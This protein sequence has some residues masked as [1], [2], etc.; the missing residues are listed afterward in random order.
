MTGVD[1]ADRIAAI[2]NQ[3]RELKMATYINC[4]RCDGIGRLAHFGHVNNGVC[5]KCRG[6][7]VVIKTKRVT[8]KVKHYVADS[9]GKRTGD[10]LFKTDK[11]GAQNL[12][13]IWK[14]QGI[15]EAVLVEIDSKVIEYVPV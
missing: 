15:T 1:A 4:D 10:V 7:K 12:V 14:E 3:H 13:N 6:A 9:S 5:L 8:T 2:H 11:E